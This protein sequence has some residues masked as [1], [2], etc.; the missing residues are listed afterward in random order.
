MEEYISKLG[1]YGQENPNRLAAAQLAA[2]EQ[3]VRHP[4][5]GIISDEYLDFKFW[6]QGLPSR[7]EWFAAYLRDEVLPPRSLRILEV[8]CGRAARLSVLLAEMGHRVTGMDPKAEP[9]AEIEVKQEAFHYENTDIGGYDLVVAQE[10][11]EAT[12]HIVRACS[13]CRVPF[14]VVLCGVPHELICGGMPGDVY[15]WYDYLAEIDPEYT[16]LDYVRMY[17]KMGVA[18]IRGGMKQ[19]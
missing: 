8:G 16:Q 18:V 15:E 7:Q 3:E 13:R 10:P 6:C 14:V 9:W 2:L 1:E 11:C 5:K 17:P 4:K 19:P 12:E